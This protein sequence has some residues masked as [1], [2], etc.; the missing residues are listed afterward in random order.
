[1]RIRRH[2]AAI[3]RLAIPVV[4]AFLTT[5][6]A[7]G[8]GSDEGDADAGGSSSSGGTSSGGTSSGGTSSGG[9]SSGG[10][11]AG[12]D[13]G[14]AVSIES[15]DLNVTVQ[16]QGDAIALKGSVMYPADC[17]PAAPCPLVVVVADR[18]SDAYPKL[19]TP[20][21]KLA[22]AAHVVVVIFNLPGMGPGSLKSGGSNDYGGPNHVAAAK[23]V[24]KLL[25]NRGYVDPARTGYLT[26]GT[27]LIA[28]ARALKLHGANTLK[29]VQFLVDVEGPTDRCAITQSPADKDRGIGPNDGPGVTDATCH[30]TAESPHSA[31]YPAAKDGNPDSIVC[32]PGAWPITKTGEDCKATIWW[33]GREP[34]NELKNI[35]TRYQRIQFEYDHRQPS[36]FSSRHAYSAVAASGSR[37]F[38]L[39]NLPPCKSLPDEDFCAKNPCWLKGDFGNGMAPAPYAGGNLSAISTDA[40]FGEV[41]PGYLLR[42][43]DEKT[44]KACK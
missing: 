32:S 4:A 31:I 34:I 37:W 21:E 2:L 27:G 15:T 12:V 39:N 38:T 18:D 8:C 17:Q 28:V 36:H 7:A 25:S 19:E 9:A 23:E 24:M 44:Y 5:S 42:I 6:L 20:A 13:T 26:I 22:A 30:F 33:S 10:T 43:M 11:D 16:V 1:M 41:L 40:L 14:P 3:S 29:S 35:Q